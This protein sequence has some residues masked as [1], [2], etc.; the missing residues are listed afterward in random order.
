MGHADIPS[1][2]KDKLLH[3]APP[4]I[5]KEAQCLVDLFGFWTQHIPH[6]GVLLWTHISSF[7]WAWNRRSSSTDL[8]C[9]EGLSTNLDHMIQQT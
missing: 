2:A 5:K 8:G 7:E 1:K 3:L 4:T 6:L 9:C